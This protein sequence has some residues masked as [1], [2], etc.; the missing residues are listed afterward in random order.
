MIRFI[1]RNGRFGLRFSLLLLPLVFVAGCG[2]E[3][4]KTFTAKYTIVERD[5]S[6]RCDPEEITVRGNR[7]TITVSN[8]GARAHRF[9]SENLDI[10]ST[11]PAGGSETYEFEQIDSSPYLFR[12]GDA[13]ANLF[14][15]KPRTSYNPTDYE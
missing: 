7:G 9:H 6:A 2:E 8:R 13:N 5:G 15:K 14:V 11:I 4:V 1:S 10:D 12:C 3:P